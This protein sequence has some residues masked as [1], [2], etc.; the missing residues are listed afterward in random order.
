MPATRYA[1]GVGFS[2]ARDEQSRIV[3]HY[4]TERQHEPVQ[5][6]QLEYDCTTQQWMAPISDACLQR[7]AECYIAVYLERRPRKAE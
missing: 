7:Q 4:V 1:D 2:L 3:L 5:Y 6:G